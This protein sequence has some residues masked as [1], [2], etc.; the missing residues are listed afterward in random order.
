MKILLVF[1][2]FLGFASCSSLDVASMVL[3]G[4]GGKGSSEQK[5]SDG[6]AG[7]KTSQGTPIDVSAVMQ[8]YATVTTSDQTYPAGADLSV[9]ASAF[10]RLRV[11]DWA[12][13]R[14]L[15]N[16]TL[17]SVMKVA[18]VGKTGSAWIYEFVSY[19]GDSAGA[20][21]MAVEGLD[22]AMKTGDTSQEKVL[23][24]KSKDKNGKITTIDGA[25]LGMMGGV[26]QNALNGNSFDSTAQITSGG[27]LTVP[28]GTFTSTWKVAS[29]VTN[30]RSAE[31]GTAWISSV[32]P[33]WHV[34]KSVSDNGSTTMELVAFG[35]SG[36][37][38]EF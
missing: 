23:W 27:S 38:S 21:Q 4:T 35:T 37:V 17:S 20:M 6:P 12:V 15:R 18:I 34:V 5:T 29:N 14:I 3:N 30:G 11:G 26:T 28:A 24:M 7:P 25:M 13:Y 2:A 1:L 19:H 22:Q 9:G 31:K 32:V 36:Y 16:G 33:V 10:S 8:K